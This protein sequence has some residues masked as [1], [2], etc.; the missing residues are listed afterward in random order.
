[1]SPNSF[2]K[3]VVKLLELATLKSGR[4][5][6]AGSSSSNTI[7]NQKSGHVANLSMNAL[8]THF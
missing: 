6:A 7:N 2:V 3:D 5:D 8:L 4:A 1:M